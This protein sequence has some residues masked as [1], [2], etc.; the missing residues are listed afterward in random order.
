MNQAAQIVLLL[1]S[2]AG[3][4]WAQSP[5]VINGLETTPLTFQEGNSPTFLSSSIRLGSDNPI[6]RV[7]V[8]LVGY[9]AGEDQL[10]FS[11]TENVRGAVDETTGTLLLLS[12][13][14]GSS[15]PA[16]SFQNAL[17]TVTYQNTNE[18]NPETDVR[19]VSFQAFDNQNQESTPASRTLTVVAENDA[20]NVILP[21]D[22]PITYP[23]GA[24]VAVPIFRTIEVTDGDSE[25]INSA[26]VTISTGFQNA[27]D[28]LLLA[29]VPIELSVTGQGSR[30]LTLSGPA[31]PATFQRALRSVQFSN[32][33]PSDVLPTEG[34]RRA[35]V[36]VFDGTAESVP[37]SRFVVVGTPANAPPSIQAFSKEVTAG[38][39]LLFTS[40]EFAEQYDD[41]EDDPFT[42]IYIRS[43][44]ER[45][46]L[47]LRGEEVTN[48][49]INDAGPNG[50]RVASTEFAALTYQAPT[51]YVGEDQFLWNAIDGTT[52]AANSKPVRI[53]INPAE[54]TL[55]LGTVDPLSTSANQPLPVPPLAFS[56]TQQ[57]PV[58]VTLSVGNGAVSLP[59][60][61][62]SLLT[63]A[64]GDGTD[65]PSLVFTGGADA[66]EYALSGIR[67]TSDE[68]YQGTE[69]L[70][71]NVSSS[72]NSSAQT[73]VAITVTSNEAPTVSDL[74]I[75]T[76]EDQPYVFRLADFTEGY[77]DADNA[78]SSGPARIHLTALP[79]NGTL[80]HQGDNLQPTDIS[81]AEGYAVPVVDVVDGQLAYVPNPGFSGRDSARWNAF[82]GEALA[83]SDATIQISVLSALAI[84]LPQDSLAVCPGDT[85]TLRVTIAA[86]PSEE[87]TYRWNC[88]SD[89]GFEQPSDQASVLISPTQNTTYVVTV[90]NPTTGDFVV[91]SIAVVVTDCPDSTL[92]LSIP[93]TF[94]PNGDDA[95]NEWAIGS[96]T[97]SPPVAVEVFDRYGHSVY[98]NEEYQDD[99][100]GTYQGQALPEGTYYYLVTGA[101]G[102]V[103]KGPLTILR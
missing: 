85:D 26:E 69:T 77:Q 27:E 55:S 56:A 79:E 36:S 84:T 15:Q 70:A 90:T 28:R 97:A 6:T 52:F 66:V 83:E 88:P 44:P 1:L 96:Q 5:P 86:T 41:P 3:T 11:D 47:L 23:A 75:S 101:G 81:S 93:N 7:E 92:T 57:V 8:Q 78:P 60:E 61:I 59:A 64:A 42:G 20:P 24:G 94:T 37:A 21:S 53:T 50:L 40:A 89:C 98:R 87:V 103:Y 71:V 35:T 39:T 51:D 43:K 67:Y 46:T 65:D 4:V 33:T 32:Q 12:Y 19:T 49:R 9:V 38:N 91:D 54:L 14:A 25:L 72:N 102:E 17:R 100:D 45:G 63:F 31:P 34:I 76:G 2:A 48:N 74:T 58:T 16:V 82:D 95:N 22:G 29:D 30:T 18:V 10:M 73:S 80:V 62:I 13:P 99:W 68:S